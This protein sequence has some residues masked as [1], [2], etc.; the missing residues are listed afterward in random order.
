MQSLLNEHLKKSKMNPGAETFL[1]LKT[2][3]IASSIKVL[4]CCN[5][6]PLILLALGCPAIQPVRID[7][8]RHAWEDNR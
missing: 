7:A 8:F 2:L 1:L 3:L 4:A 5:Y 6:D